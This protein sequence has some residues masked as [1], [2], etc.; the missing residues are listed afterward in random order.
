LGSCPLP[1][2]RRCGKTRCG[3]GRSLQSLSLVE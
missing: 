1:G 3:C 2:Q